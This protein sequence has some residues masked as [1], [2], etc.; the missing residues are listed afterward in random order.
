MKESSLISQISRA[1]IGNSPV[2]EKVGLWIASHPLRV[3]SMSADDVARH[4]G[5]SLAAVNRFARSA[6]F[7][8][9][10]HLKT[11]LS[12]ELQETSEPIR[13]LRSGNA[14][15]ASLADE[16]GLFTDA[17]NNVRVASQAVTHSM[18]DEAAGHLLAS[19]NV[20][21]L[22]LGLGHCLAA[23]A[24]HLLLPYLKTVISLAGEGGTEIAAR[25]LM[26]VGPNDTL[27]AVSIPRY[28]RETVALA[29][30]ARQRGAFVIAITD[31]PSAPIATMAQL[32]LLAPSTHSTLSSSGVGNLAVIE[33]LAGRVMQRKTNAAD[34]ATRLSEAV[35]DY[36]SVGGPKGHF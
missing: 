2:L 24:A 31:K 13:K 34:I 33:A 30:Y 11:A 29:R 9:F 32:S 28:S 27:I 20:F 6:G 12:V 35:L 1:A 10:S 17:A 3:I 22:G 15:P 16:H 5:S 7:D 18:I 4:A 23:A 25:R 14:G 26:H 21:T 36:L 19:E 8:G